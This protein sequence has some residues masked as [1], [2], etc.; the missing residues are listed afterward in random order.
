M[1]NIISLEIIIDLFITVL[2]S[3]YIPTISETIFSGSSDLG[4]APTKCL[5]NGINHYQSFLNSDG[6][7]EVEG[8]HLGEYLQGYYV[9]LYPL[10]FLDTYEARTAWMLLNIL[11][12]FLIHYFL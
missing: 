8:S 12:I 2:V 7:C 11:L 1:K 5:F 9:M 4:I 6:K 10:V 3:S